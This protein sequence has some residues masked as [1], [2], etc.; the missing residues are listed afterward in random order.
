MNESEILPEEQDDELFEHHRIVA[1]PGQ[2]QLR[3][4][5]FLMARLPN[6][7]RTKI[8]DGIHMGFVKVNEKPIK[9]NYKVHPDDTITVSLPQPPR[10][11][12]VI[13]ENIPLT[14]VYE[15]DHLLVI[16]KEA[17]MV[18]HP[19]YQNWS[20]TLVNA[21]T[22]HFQN[23]PQ[24]PGNDGRPGLVHRI[25]KDT[26]GLLVVAK[27]EYTLTHLAKQFFDHSIERTYWAL[28]W[29]VPDPPQGTIDVHVG[30]SLKDRRVT[31]AFPDGDFGRHAI[32]HYRLLQDLRY[33]SL[34]ECRLETGRTHQI[35]A[36]MKHIGHTLFNDAM[37]G[38]DQVLKGTVF[39][40]YK[41]FVDNCFQLI[42][43]QALHAK[44]LGFIHPHTKTFMRFDSDLPDDFKNVMLKW[45]HYVKYN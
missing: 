1:D 11:T 31:T 16:N 30:R 32:T 23:L 45:E 27:N 40:K 38:G 5:K 28:A 29:G 22:Y 42:P 7:T 20:G 15:D 4:D 21:L 6:V 8:Q 14:I 33:V 39:S 34:V 35:R 37:Y 19:A 12:E 10:D 36:H 13:P 25:D 3:I 18:V 43:R 44:T 41:Q 2:A 26:S 24:M 17:G 9:P